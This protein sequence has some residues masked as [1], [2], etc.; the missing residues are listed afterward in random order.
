MQSMF[1]VFFISVFL[2]NLF[3]IL[4]TYM[5]HSVWRAILDNFRPM[6]VWGGD[7][8]IFY[9]VS[10]LYGEPWSSPG[11]NVQLLGLFV[12]LYGTAIYNAPN[13]GSILLKGEIHSC[14]LDY[15]SDYHELEVIE[16]TSV[17]Q[18]E[19]IISLAALPSPFLHSPFLT[20]RR[21]KD[22]TPATASSTASRLLAMT[23]GGS[24]YGG[25][26]PDDFE[27]GDSFPLKK[28]ASLN[29]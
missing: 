26:R 4:V 21:I 2:Y 18:F 17:E 14:G 23:A 27:G 10:S 16:D 15:S 1:V 8:I 6:T 20:P 5:L 28:T 3:G 11:S 9:A 22:G 13:P 29:L 7:M 12:L 19:P 25:L 24:S